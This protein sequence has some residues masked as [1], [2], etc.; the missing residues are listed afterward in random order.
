MV[1][2]CGLS[3]PEVERIDD[4]NLVNQGALSEQ[5]V[6]QHL[7]YAQP[8]YRTP[9]LYYWMREKSGSSAEVDYVIATSGRI[10]PVEVKSGK[11]GRLKSLQLFADQK[12]CDLA[13]RFNSDQPSLTAAAITYPEAKRESYRL[14]S[15]PFYLVQQ[16]ERIV[17][18]LA[19]V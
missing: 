17:G 7:L 19:H 13:V 18:G 2:A 16:V 11:S 8:P 1:S 14:V 6:G 4:L 12:A 9:E 15:L 3:L 10:V 5:F